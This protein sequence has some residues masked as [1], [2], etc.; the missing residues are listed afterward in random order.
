M[1]AAE[2]ANTAVVESMDTGSRFFD[3][4]C[5]FL[6]GR[7]GEEA[8]NEMNAAPEMYNAHFADFL[9]DR[10]VDALVLYWNVS[11]HSA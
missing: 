6:A 9:I 7:V 11:Q 3:Q 10:D 1:S 4:W 5:I 8:V 2:I